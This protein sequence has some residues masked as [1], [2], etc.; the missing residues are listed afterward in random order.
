MDHDSN[1]MVRLGDRCEGTFHHVVNAI[2]RRWPRP[3]PPPHLFNTCH[4]ISHRGEHDNHSRFENTL[5][6]FDMAATAGVWGIELDVRWT[7]DQIPIVFHDPDT[8][9]LYGEYN[10]I[11]HMTLDKLKKSSP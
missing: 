6:A 2:Y 10:R 11:G 4:I 3:N 1:R 9:R 5:P 8:R 7:R